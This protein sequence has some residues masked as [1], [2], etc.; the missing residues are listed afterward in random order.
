MERRNQSKT[1][2]KSEVMTF[3]HKT[4]THFRSNSCLDKTLYI[5]GNKTTYKEVIHV[6]CLKRF[7]QLQISTKYYY[8]STKTKPVYIYI[9]IYQNGCLCED[10][11]FYLK[12][13]EVRIYKTWHHAVYLD[14]ICTAQR[15]VVLGI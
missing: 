7:F 6:C 4:L 14:K 10:R 11:Y 9:Y 15:S 12:L 13:V 3:C 5:R 8:K 2:I 1:N